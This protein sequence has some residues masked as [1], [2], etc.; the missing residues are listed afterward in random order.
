[1]SNQ[2]ALN[3]NQNDIDLTRY[4]LVLIK[5]YKTLIFFGIIALLINFIVQLNLVKIYSAE[6]EVKEN[7]TIKFLLSPFDIE[8]VK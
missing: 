8:S 7:D 6:L 5:D 3:Y 4:L 2:T 1:M